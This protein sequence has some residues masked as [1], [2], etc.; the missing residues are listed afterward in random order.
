MQ[1]STVSAVVFDWGGTLTPWHSVDPV[2]AWLAAT[3]DADLATRLHA[4]EL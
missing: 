2:Q 4:A 3:D 1:Q